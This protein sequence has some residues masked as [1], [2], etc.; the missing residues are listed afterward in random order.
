ML[1]GSKEGGSVRFTW[2]VHRRDAETRQA[3]FVATALTAACLVGISLPLVPTY[4]AE[5]RAAAA[6]AVARGE[7]VTF[8]API[9]R[10][11]TSAQTRNDTTTRRTSLVSHD[12]TP[13]IVP[14]PSVPQ[15]ADSAAGGGIG[16]T[17]LID[18]VS[19][20]APTR[21]VVGPV[22]S[23]SGVS[24]SLVPTAPIPLPLTR[25]LTQEE[26]DVIH[27]EDDQ[28]L[29]AARADHRPSPIPLGGGGIPVPL[30]QFSRGPSPK[31]RIKDSIVNADNLPRLARLAERA[32][33]KRDSLRRAD[34][35]AM[36]KKAMTTADR[37]NR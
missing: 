17:L 26:L 7:I 36:L 35:L 30:P 32:R 5:Q 10:P 18:S 6:S 24:R 23:R 16:E 31:Q 37:R 14:L 25:A 15:Q 19:A 28:R 20:A 34:S 3:S 2:L 8:V 22:L 4:R 29:A 9:P 21:R 11:T 12:P 1:G 27:R 33:A 13:S